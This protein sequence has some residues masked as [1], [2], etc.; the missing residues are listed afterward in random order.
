MVFVHTLWSGLG[1]EGHVET[2]WLDATL[3]AHA[4]ARHKLVIGHHPVHPVN[5]FE[6]PFQREIG[7]PH[8]EAF[9]AILVRHGVLVRE[10]RRV[11][12]TKIVPFAPG[13]IANQ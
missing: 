6:G 2:D 7:P 10:R 3:A 11:A 1:G 4:N 5:G 12:L 8:A 9:W 13:T